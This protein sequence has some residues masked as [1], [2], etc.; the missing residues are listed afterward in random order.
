MNIFCSTPATNNIANIYFEVWQVNDAGATV[1]TIIATSTG[2]RTL[3]SG[4]TVATYINSLYVPFTTLQAI[5]GT[6]ITSYRVQIQVFAARVSGGGGGNFNLSTYYRDST[7]SHIH[8]S[9]S[10]VIGATGPTGQMPLPTEETNTGATG[11]VWYDT[12]NQLFKYDAAKTFV[13]DNPVNPN[14]YLVHACLEGPEA[15]VYYRGKGEIANDNSVTI[16]MPYY[17]SALATD[18]TIQ[19]TPI[20]DGKIKSFGVSEIV[21]NKF[22]VYGENGKFYWIVHGS[23][24]NVD[25]DPDKTAV[26]VKGSGP[27]LWI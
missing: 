25:V 24:S 7:Q 14:K 27:Y 19:V 16:E 22:T 10:N 12:A 17:V 23:R 21:D 8:T 11:G 26:E 18:F 3:V 6:T 4:T 9:L 20:Y 2:D 1:G 15:G 5:N 13:I